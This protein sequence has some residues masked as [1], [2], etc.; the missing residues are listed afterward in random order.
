MG[1]MFSIIAQLMWHQ[2]SQRKL[3]HARLLYVPGLYTVLVLEDRHRVSRA[4]ESR[5]RSDRR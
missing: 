3:R 1:S 5:A 2:C 4:S